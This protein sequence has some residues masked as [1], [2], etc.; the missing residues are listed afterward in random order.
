[1]SNSEANKRMTKN[2]LLLY[3]RMFYGLAISLYTSRV[4]LEALGFV[5]YGLYNAIGSV[6]MMF[7]FLRSA[8]GNSVHRHIT[9]AIG[10]GDTDRIQN[11][12]S[13]SMMIHIGLSLA[14]IVLSETL[15]LWFLNTQINIPEGRV[16]AANWVF[17]FSIFTCA[18][19][20]ICVPYDAEIIAHERLGFFALIQTVQSTL[21]LVIAYLIKISH[22]D[23][24]ILYAFLLFMIQVL[25]RVAY[26][27]YCKREFKETKFKWIKDKALFKEM[28]NFA[29]WSLIGNL[30]YIGY[31]S[32]LNILINILFGPVINASRG[33]AMQLQGAI[34]GFVTNFQMAINPQ[35]TKSYAEG[36][37]KRMHSLIYTSSKFSFFLLLCIVLPVSIET[38][39]I[40]HIW[41]GNTPPYT[42]PFVILT[43]A[44]MLIEPLSNPIGI[45]NDATGKIR[46]YQIIQGGF[47]LLIVPLA[48]IAVKMGGDP[49][50]VFVIQLVVM[51]LGHALRLLLV[52]HKIQMSI[53]VYINKV[54]VRLCFATVISAILPLLTYYFMDNSVLS[55]IIV[56]LVSVISVI[57]SAFLFGLDRTEQS[58]VAEKIKFII[59]KSLSRIV[60]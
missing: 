22:C 38:K 50:S 55:C 7:V 35:I 33:I 42:V 39:T 29:G 9:F 54:I 21:N 6:V 36:N 49:V 12:F 41:L 43:L 14:I 60:S 52:C 31:T 37:V 48:F 26:S 28:C 56:F 19:S 3:G 53:K 13:M 15:G 40:L 20:I 30:S 4:I 46:N 47:M 2:T 27:R 23:R 45:A 5:D 10:K 44:T 24:L 51:G 34:K 59:H 57:G 11:V 58:F 25:N 32:G 18:M 17:Q 8:M 16:Y 1:M